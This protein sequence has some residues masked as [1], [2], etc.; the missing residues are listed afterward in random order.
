MSEPA[1]EVT[2]TSARKH[3][4]WKVICTLSAA[5]LALATF[6]ANNYFGHPLEPYVS[7]LYDQIN[8]PSSQKIVDRAEDWKTAYAVSSNLQSSP[9]QW[10]SYDSNKGGITE[11]FIGSNKDVTV[12][13][14]SKSRGSLAFSL[15]N[16]A[17]LPTGDFFLS[18]ELENEDGCEYGLVFRANLNRIFGWLSIDDASHPYIELN[19]LDSTGTLRQVFFKHYNDVSSIT[20]MGI[21]QHGNSYIIE[22]SGKVLGVV[23]GSKIDHIVGSSGLTGT[24][25]GLGT[26]SCDT[27]ASYTFR[28]I[29]IQEP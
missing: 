17:D 13:V 10:T 3:F 22:I 26:W 25:F 12:D 6:I 15:D 23:S 9:P 5:F 18:T 4:S 8:P 11:K 1:V 28:N 20:S 21:V 7:N 16:S 2:L 24:Q 29:T 19:I 27:T 14:S